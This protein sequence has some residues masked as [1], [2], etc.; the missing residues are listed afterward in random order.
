M[1]F[2][3][4]TL[5][6]RTRSGIVP[7]AGVYSLLS[8]AKVLKLDQWALYGLDYQSISFGKIFKDN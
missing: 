3:L 8:L 2:I 7:Y 6:W 4:V 5:I 1:L